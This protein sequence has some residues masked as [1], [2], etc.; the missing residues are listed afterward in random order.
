MRITRHHKETYG[1]HVCAGRVKHVVD[2]GLT[3]ARRDPHDGG[4]GKVADAP[5]GSKVG[6]HATESMTT[7]HSCGEA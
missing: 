2:L 5:G 7:K 6:E 3:V 4:A 1:W